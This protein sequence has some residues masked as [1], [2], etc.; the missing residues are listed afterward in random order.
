MKKEHLTAYFG[1]A[2]NPEQFYT[3]G[4]KAS[5]D[6]PK[7][8]LEQGLNAYEYSAGRGVKLKEET[9]QK[10]GAKALEYGIKLSVH[11]P[12]YINLATFD[13]EQMEKNVNYFITTVQA[14]QYMGADRV[15]FHAGGQGKNE[16]KIAVE[17]VKK[18]LA[19]VLER[20]VKLDY[21]TVKLLPETMGKKGQIGTLEEVIDF[22]K[23]SPL[24]E[25]TVDFGHLHAVAEGAYM[26]KDEYLRAFDMIGAGLGKD[27]LQTLHVHFSKI[28]Y[29]K[30]GEKKHWTFA[31]DFGPPFEP[32]IEAVVDYGL[33]PRVISESA[34]TQD[35]DAFVMKEYYEK[36]C[37]KK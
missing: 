27:V 30:A 1:T 21:T 20:L 24:L 28:E 14:A 18:R 26:T 10:I 36:C 19:Q 16:R 37:K 31:D 25:P 2:G 32:F 6:M 7:W 35:K 9:A 12:Y 13:S 5:V 22:C 15:V 17:Q 8:L 4:L 33:T 29:T 3:D 23:L 34:G 11:A